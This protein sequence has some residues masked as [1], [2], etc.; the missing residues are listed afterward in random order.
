MPWQF[1]ENS[2]R[3]FPKWAISVRKAQVLSEFIEAEKVFWL[4]WILQWRILK[5]AL[6]PWKKRRRNIASLCLP[7]GNRIFLN[8]SIYLPT[9]LC[10]VVI[11]PRP[12]PCWGNTVH[13]S[14]IIN[15]FVCLLL[16]SPTYSPDCPHILCPAEKVLSFSF[17]HLPPP[18]RYWEDL[19]EPMPSW[20]CYF[21]LFLC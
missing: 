10:I 13:V 15:C 6:S 14:H 17:H 9:Y 18:S 5:L 3:L 20:F 8:P 7:K 19:P 1:Q 21:D 4:G 2:R 12:F 16:L 11:E